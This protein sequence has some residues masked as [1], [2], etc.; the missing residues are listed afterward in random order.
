[1]ASCTL[2]IDTKPDSDRRRETR[3]VLN[4]PRTRVGA[5]PARL[6]VD[7]LQNRKRCLTQAK[8]A[9]RTA[10]FGRGARP[11][12]RAGLS[13]T[14][15]SVPRCT[16]VAKRTGWVGAEGDV[17]GPGI[18]VIGSERLRVGHGIL[19]RG[20][21]SEQQRGATVLIRPGASAPHRWSVP[22]QR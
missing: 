1:V 18:G 12:A 6:A 17:P 9:C 13:A 10:T 15:H 4:G 11:Q 20:L 2:R 7:R 19:P 16:S 22:C 21:R 8:N 14:R 3:A 5:R